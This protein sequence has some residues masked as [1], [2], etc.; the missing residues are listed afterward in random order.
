VPRTDP[1]RPH[2]SKARARSGAPQ[3]PRKLLFG[4]GEYGLLV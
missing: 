4:S 2:A 3:T 1:A